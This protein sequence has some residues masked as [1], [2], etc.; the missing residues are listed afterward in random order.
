[1]IVVLLV[2]APMLQA[3]QPQA[4]SEAYTSEDANEDAALNA[5][6]E[7]DN[8]VEGAGMAVSGMIPD[9]KGHVPMANVQ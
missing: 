3:C 4:K 9:D 1:M 7:Q 2:G 6:R 8:E 5:I